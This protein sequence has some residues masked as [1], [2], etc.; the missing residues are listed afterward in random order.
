[1]HL[2]ARLHAAVGDSEQ[3]HSRAGESARGS[4]MD[5]QNQYTAGG[6][7]WPS[8]AAA[9][10]VKGAV[11]TGPRY[12]RQLSVLSIPGIRS[13][14]VRTTSKKPVGNLRLQRLDV[15]RS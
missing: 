14:W 2:V 11:R 12:W 1:M 8:A 13:R 4:T 10:L 9:Q 7:R 15:A 6:G 5:R 3:E